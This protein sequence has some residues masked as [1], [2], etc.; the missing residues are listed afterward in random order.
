[1]KENYDNLNQVLNLDMLRVKYLVNT[2][3]D[4]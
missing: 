4:M 2:A 3:E 1:M